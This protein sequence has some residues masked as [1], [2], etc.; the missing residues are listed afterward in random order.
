MPFDQFDNTRFH[1]DPLMQLANATWTRSLSRCKSKVRVFSQCASSSVFHP[2]S[3][4]DQLS[5]SFFKLQSTVNSVLRNLHN[6]P[7]LYSVRNWVPRQILCSRS[8]KHLRIVF[9]VFYI[10]LF[11]FCSTAIGKRNPSSISSSFSII[12]FHRLRIYKLVWEQWMWISVCVSLSLS[13]CLFLSLCFSLSL[14]LTT[15]REQKQQ[16]AISQLDNRGES[17]S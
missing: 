15:T 2:S 8:V 10:L 12:V 3:S 17:S 16:F 14:S 11:S 7:P 1:H 6:R 4:P 5:S 9:K 13:V